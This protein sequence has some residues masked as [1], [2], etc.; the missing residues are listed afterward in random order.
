MKKTVV[1]SSRFSVK[2]VC[3]IDFGSEFSACRLLKFIA[4]ILK[5]SLKYA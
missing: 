5:C 1:A 4:I 3:Y 2:L